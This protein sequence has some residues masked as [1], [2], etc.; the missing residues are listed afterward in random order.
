MAGGLRD[1]GEGRIEEA[2]ICATARF[3]PIEIF[4]HADV[5]V[6]PTWTSWA[7]DIAQVE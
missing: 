4:D 5:I 3:A 6:E 2:S 1:A 7:F